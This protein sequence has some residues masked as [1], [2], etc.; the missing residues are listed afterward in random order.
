M[1][2]RVLTLNLHS[3][4]NPPKYV[5][6]YT[7]GKTVVDKKEG[8]IKYLKSKS[9]LDNEKKLFEVATPIINAWYDS[10]TDK[11]LISI[12]VYCATA[13]F[14]RLH[15]WGSQKIN[16]YTY[17]FEHDWNLIPPKE[18]KEKPVEPEPEPKYQTI[19]LLEL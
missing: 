19:V 11:H 8:E 7:D 1:A 15:G 2:G 4:D 13:Q 3:Y 5:I 9:K 12:R 18:E 14:P 6:I 16:G 10:F 17:N